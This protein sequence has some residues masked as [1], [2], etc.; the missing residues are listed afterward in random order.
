[1]GLLNL[2]LLN[3]LKQIIEDTGEVG[4]VKQALVEHLNMDFKITISVLCDQIIPRGDILD[5]EEVSIRE[6]LRFLVLAFMTQEAKKTICERQFVPGDAAESVLYDGLFAVRVPAAISSLTTHTSPFS[7]LYRRQA[8]PHLGIDDL[9]LAVKS[10]I[11]SL[12]AFKSKRPT[13]R[14][15]ELLQLLL[16]GQVT[17]SLK[18]DSPSGSKSLSPS[19]KL[20][21]DICE[22]IT[23]VLLAAPA[24]NLLQFY[25]HSLIGKIVLQKFQPDEQQWIVGR[26]ARILGVAENQATSQ[27]PTWRRTIVDASPYLFEVCFLFNNLCH[28]DSQ[29]QQVF[30]KPHPPGPEF[31]AIYNVFIRSCLKVRSRLLELPLPYTFCQSARKNLLGRFLPIFCKYCKSIDRFKMLHKTKNM[32][33]Y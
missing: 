27:L 9:Q 23:C 5:E 33:K 8:V 10:L 15:S 32:K 18:A 22:H 28:V 2:P 30:K 12:P 16:N 31:Q 3:N 13:E 11:C 14:G 4:V 7:L 1:V 25:C 21:L 17:T 6:R 26:L 24:I 19:T 29:S 20:L